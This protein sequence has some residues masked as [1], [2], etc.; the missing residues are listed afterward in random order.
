MWS[1]KL[2]LFTG[3]PFFITSKFLSKFG[4]LVSYQGIGFKHKVFVIDPMLQ[5]Y[6]IKLGQSFFKLTFLSTCDMLWKELYHGGEIFSQIWLL[7]Q[8][9]F[10]RNICV[11]VSTSLL[12][13]KFLVYRSCNSRTWYFA[14]YLKV[15]LAHFFFFFLTITDLQKSCKYFFFFS[16]PLKRKLQV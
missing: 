14:L 1:K 5:I 11:H 9:H 4:P 13:C 12:G 2:F 7:A 6:W 10:T 3:A 16:G 8:F 15:C